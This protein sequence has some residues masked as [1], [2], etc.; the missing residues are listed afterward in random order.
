M[1][2]RPVVA[3]ERG[4]VPAWLVIGL[5]IL[6]GVLLFVV[7]DGQRR[8]ATAPTT[9]VRTVDSVQSLSTLP[10]LYIIPEPPAPPPPPLPPAEQV[11][12]P[13]PPP[14]PQYIPQ[15][16]PPSYVPPPAY[17]PPQ[18]APAPPVTSGGPALVVDTTVAAE[19]AAGSTAGPAVAA[20]L[21]RPST[22]VPQGTLIPAVLETALDS[23]PPGH[24]RAIV[25]R[26]VRGFDG[27]HVLI[28]RGTRVFGEYQADMAAGQSRAL[29]QWTRL[30]RPDGVTIAIASPAADL[31]GRAGIEGRVDSHF[32]E[33]FG[34]ALLRSTLN[35][36]SSLVGQKIGGDGS[37]IILP[38]G[39]HGAEALTANTGPRPTLRVDAG[40]RVTVFVARDLEFPPSE[41]GP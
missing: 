9:Q 31:E 32:L 8:A 17:V 18:P 6:G 22:T 20:R 14:P 28:P 41:A 30:V 40:A 33:R 29:V 4:Q 38:G 1:D 36:G 7:L 5:I 35:V 2:I 24:V 13:P 3:R 27:S 16:P 34:G 39:V 23:T 11:T 19:A 25:S 37:V 26:D 21:S 10:P 15:P 12:P